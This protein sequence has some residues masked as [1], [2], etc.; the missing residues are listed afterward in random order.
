MNFPDLPHL[1]QLQKDL[2]Q[3]PSSRAAV[4][5]G[6]GF[7]R[8][9]VSSPGVSTYFPTWH[10]LAQ[11]MF[12]EIYP[13][14]LNETAEQK[15]K[16]EE[17]FNRI[18]ELRLASEYEAAFG[19]QRLESFIHTRIPDTDHQPGDLHKLLLQLPWKD[20][21]TT[22]YDTLL[23]RTEVDGRVYQPV[24]R[25]S[26]LTTAF[27]PRIIKL[28]GSFPSQTP[29]IITEE[30][31]RTYPKD[32][33]P[34]VNTVL[35]SLLENTFVLIGFS[36]DD[37]NFLQWIGWIRDELGDRHASIYLVGP[38]SISNVQRSLLAKRGV[39][40]IDLSPVSGIHKSSIEWF[41]R[42]LLAAKP[43]RSEAWPKTKTTARGNADFEPPI[44]VS[45][46]T[47]PE[48]VNLPSSSQ[49][50][51]DEAT[52][53]KVI[54]RWRFERNR[55]PGWLVPREQLRSSLWHETRDWIEPLIK[56][57][58]NWPPPDRLL[59][60]REINW[61]L[62]ISMIPLFSNWIT[63]FES[64]INELFPNLQKRIPTKPSS[65]VMR[66]INVSDTEVAEA[67]LEIAI[68]LLREARESYNSE[69]WKTFKEKI[70]KVV[71]SHPRFTDRY[72]YEQAL[73]SVW[74]IE[75]SQAK[76]LLAEWSPSS[77]SPLPV[78]WKA[79]LLAELD[80]LN[81]ARSLLRL[82]LRETRKSLNNVQERSIHLLSLE[83][84]CTYLLFAVAHAMDSSE[85]WELR[86]E[87]SERWQELKAWDCNPW[88]LTRY[89]DEILSKTPPVPRKMKQIVRGFDPWRIHMT[90]TWGRDDME[91][92]LP[93]FACIRLYEQVGIPL[94]LPF[95]NVSGSA[96]RNACKWVAPFT[97]FWSPALL[98]RAGKKDDLTKHDFMNRA[99]IAT[100]KPDL[101]RSLNKW[102]MEALKREILSLSGNIARAS[103]QESLLEVLPEVLSR[104]AF[105]LESADLQ[106]AF[107]SALEFHSQ[108]GIPSN[109]SLH[110]SCE[111]W[112][113]RLFEAADDRQL[114]AWLP[115][116]LRFPLSLG[117]DRLSN[118]LPNPWPDPMR[119]LPIGRTCA[120][121]KIYP[122]LLAEIN[123]AIEW[124]LER[125]KSES[126]EGRR[127][128]MMRLI[129]IF[130]ANIMTEEQRNCL[131]ALLWEK[132]GEHGLLDLP[133]FHCF[134]YLHLP[135][136]AKVDVASKVKAHILSLTPIR[137]VSVG[138]AG[139]IS[140]S[141]QVRE[142]PMILNA[143][144]AS[145]AAV[146]IPYEPTGIIEWSW[147][148]AKKL[149]DKAI[150]WW[151]NEKIALSIE[152]SSPF[153]GTEH[154]SDGLEDVGTLLVRAILP[155]IDS[156]SADEWNRV[157]T[158]LSET[159][160]RGVYLTTVLP[161]VLLH[162][163]SE[164]DRIIQMIFDDLSSDNEKAVKASARAVRHWIHLADERLLDKLPNTAIDKLIQRVIFRRPQGIRT[165][166]NLLA[167]LLI[168]K[169]DVF[170][171]DQ[172]NLVVASLTPWSHAT[173]LPLSEER[174]ADF[175]EEE[176]PELRDL[177]GRLA[178]ALSI[179]L[180]NKF[181][182]QPE[183]PEIS[184][185]RESYKSDPLPEV[186]RAFD[187]WKL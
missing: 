28:H 162:R 174:V 181:P 85:G 151:D 24:T 122:E 108:P 118:P 52:V 141:G 165:C 94:H 172:V 60:F 152:R 69:R 55:Y 110:Q 130:D 12:D 173:C 147:D 21:F 148:E 127:R 139:G 49:S 135:S 68:A 144:F 20:V 146:H 42:S 59:L 178:S 157:H 32:F 83:G 140:I 171:S 113:K 56:F 66:S 95:F 103:A 29:F 87:F 27:S 4:M 175:S 3:W 40:P 156:A 99:Q 41:L 16:R 102:A 86:E 180:K 35:Q 131:G 142:D 100:M 18:N 168:E 82:A 91:T 177:L 22:N 101:A 155:K 63:P 187:T 117:S 96:L 51:L 76:G 134:K 11:A 44:L 65:N 161:Y 79:G 143:A 182:D 5:V 36:G 31:Y 62:E 84:W 149:W 124:L 112:F 64:A 70:D 164:R 77:H 105:K 137:S 92:W 126:G 114:L 116:L 26:E 57:A 10:E 72:Y 115:E 13:A 183:S 80:E 186:R 17:R 78:M 153:F 54:E 8:N 34:F 166:L 170:N 23:E 50:P 138:T 88:H 1:Q 109:I 53:L 15:T 93:A 129:Y 73:W 89:F 46:S 111:P 81:E 176:R 39:T 107:S 38:L 158:F 121:K 19:S 104:L 90:H 45:G 30:H 37:P 75:R 160:R 179:W 184:H 98:I 33:A 14:S 163:L 119:Q 6:A 106:E 58:E 43:Q 25:A 133:D 128:A 169:P 154:I 120:A 123:E 2:W 67:W 74:N 150:E 47:E 125:V 132:S 71:V 159:R 97:S 48:K 61:R 145:K 167:I 185:L 7:S 9:S 136:P